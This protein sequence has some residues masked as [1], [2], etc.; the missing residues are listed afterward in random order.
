MAPNVLI[1]GASGYLGGSLL[2]CIKDSAPLPS[3]NKLDA[4][5]RTEERTNQ[6]QTHY[7]ATP[8][9]MDLSN[10]AKIEERLLENE[11][12]IVFSLI[13]AFKPDSQLLFI[14]ALQA[15]GKRYG[16][17]THFV[18]TT[19]AELFSKFVGHLTSRDFSE[20]D[21]SLYDLQK[22]S[23]SKWLVMKSVRCVEVFPHR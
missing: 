4:L 11:I 19:G 7:N 3:R 2:E 20:A 16:I 14:K 12:S 1:T 18:H 5:V 15:V 21:E 10:G 23:Q 8:W 17:E 22:Q 9:T 6:V 13:G